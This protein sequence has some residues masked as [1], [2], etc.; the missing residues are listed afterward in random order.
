MSV[1]S[2][3]MRPPLSGH[4]AQRG[5]PERRLAAARLAHDGHGL[6]ARDVEDDVADGVHGP[7]R[8]ER[9]AH[10]E[11]DAEHAR[12]AGAV[13]APSSRA[14]RRASAGAAR[15]VVADRRRSPCSSALVGPAGS[16]SQQRAKCPGSRPRQSGG[17][18]ALAA[19]SKTSGQRGAKRQPAARRA[20]RAAR[21]AGSGAG[22]RRAGCG[23]L[24]RRRCV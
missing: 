4:Q 16:T 5:A 6:A 17:A 20:G 19:G 13:R 23:M 14:S 10:E 1:P 8:E 12:C 2:K 9:R 22:A 24:A 21:P 7:A 15:R 18:S 11:V 3:T